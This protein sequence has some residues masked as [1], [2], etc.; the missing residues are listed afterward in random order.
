VQFTL[1]AAARHLGYSKSTLTRAVHSGKLSATRR[2]DGSYV[3]DAAELVRAF[4]PRPSTT[5]LPTGAM[6]H[7]TPGL[8]EGVIP[9][10]E[11][12]TERERDALLEL[13][14]EHREQIID[15]RRRLDTES[16]E[17]RAAQEQVRQL[18]DQRREAG[19][20]EKFTKVNPAPPGSLW[21]RFRR[22]S[23]GGP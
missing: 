20:T 19:P 6:M 8:D 18:T 21:R 23:R 15:L 11:R 12:F 13:I 17:R 22:W 9:V 5:G 10:V 1:G 16:E 14:R 7:Q 4:P 3:I 2:E